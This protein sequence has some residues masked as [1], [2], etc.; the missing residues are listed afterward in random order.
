MG[1]YAFKT[2]TRK[3]EAYPSLDYTYREKPPD[4]GIIEVKGSFRDIILFIARK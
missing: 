4:Q 3:R 1:A 2:I